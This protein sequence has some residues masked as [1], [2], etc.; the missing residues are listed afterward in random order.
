MKSTRLLRAIGDIDEGYVTEATSPRR[1]SVWMAVGAIAACVAVTLSVVTATH[2]NQKPN[3]IDPSDEP[4]SPTQSPTQTKPQPDPPLPIINVIPSTE[5]AM[6]YE[7]YIAPTIDDMNFPTPWRETDKIQTL[8]VYDN[9]VMAERYNVTHDLTPTEAEKQAMAADLI[10]M[11]KKL[12]IPDPQ[13]V[14]NGDYLPCYSLAYGDYVLTADDTK[15]RVFL[16]MPEGCS[17]ET[18]DSYDTLEA[19]AYR[20]LETYRDVIGL[21]NPRLAISYGDYTINGEQMWMNVQFYEQGDIPAE[22]LRNYCFNSVHLLVWNDSS[23]QISFD[24]L[25]LS[26]VIGEYALISVEEAKAAL[27]E[28]YYVTSAADPFPGLDHIEQV[29]ITYRNAFWDNVFLPYYKFYV[30]EA[31]PLPGAAQMGMKSYAT[32]YVP[33]VQRQYIQGLPLW[34]GSINS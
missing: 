28:G 29:E 33:A 13:P 9:S 24:R 26:T 19:S 22:T 7:G 31:D 11:A 23:L 17:L 12:G 6:G 20:I 10:Y 27:L 14:W 25:D 18:T 8:P 34:D 15:L 32:Y 3:L 30:E 2:L 5:G 21:K 16:P 1:R 4:I